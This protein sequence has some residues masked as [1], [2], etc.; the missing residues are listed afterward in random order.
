[1]K[2]LNYEHI[3]LIGI[4]IPFLGTTLGS[5][6]VVFCK[7]RLNLGVQ[8]VFCGF[9]AGVM[10]AASVWSLIIPSIEMAKSQGTVS[11][12]PAS[13]GII[14]GVL[15]LC[16]I[17]EVIRKTRKNKMLGLAITLHNIPEGMA[18]GVAF[19]SAISIGTEIAFLSAFSIAVGIAV[20]NIPEG[21]AI[22]LPLRV[23]GNSRLKSFVHGTLSGI[24]EPIA[25]VITIL[26]SGI[27]KKFL[28][29]LLAFAAGSM[30]YV[31]IKELIPESQEGK[32]SNMRFNWSNC[33]FFDN[34]GF[35]C[36]FRIN[37]F[38]KSRIHFYS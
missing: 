6:L 5:S 11:W 31:V 27:I 25:S 34:D 8:K 4:L 18:I 2:K 16:I 38:F 10:I 19:A 20:Q 3:I 21:M 14:L 35:R 29:V 12:I 1:M 17:D 7:N 30:L 36:Y 22:A 9:A 15:F 13:L 23:E 37:I 28:P 32:Y 33:W 24:V 26:I